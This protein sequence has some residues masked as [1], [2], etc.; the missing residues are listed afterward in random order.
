MR[1]EASVRRRPELAVAGSAFVLSLAVAALIVRPFHV[2]TAGYDAAASVLYFER[3]S[4]GRTLEAFVGATPKALLTGV[5]GV[6]FSIVP[7]W[8]VVSWLAILAYAAGIS[9]SAT[10]AYRLAGPVA[11]G[12]VAVGLVG[13]A[14]LLQDVDLAYAVSWALLACAVAGLLVSAPKPRYAW[15]GLTLAVGGLARAETLII[16]VLAG[17]LIVAGTLIARRRGLPTNAL[18]D[19]GPILLG[20]LAIP[21][22]AGH[23]WLLTGDPLYA[24]RVPVLGSVG[25]PLVGVPGAIRFVIGH[26]AGEPLLIVLAVVG[27]AALAIRRR[28]D[29]VTGLLAL[30]PGVAAFIVFLG[31][32]RIYV[33]N[34]Y[35]APADL[36]ITFA[37]GIGLANVSVPLLKRATR[38]ARRGTGRALAAALVG[39]LVAFVI[40][41]PFGPI[42]LPTRRAIVTNGLV[43]RDVALVIAPIDA[44]LATL[45]HARDWPADGSPTGPT[46]TRAV[47]LV[48]ILTVPQMA[49]DLRLPLSTLTGTVATSI[50]TDGSYPRI[51][52]LVFH[53]VDRDRPAAAFRIFEVDRSTSA[54]AILLNPILVDANHRFWLDRIDP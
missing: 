42:D 34:R 12:F 9:A 20:L 49:V 48:P 29:V 23:D 4:S 52:Q 43:H 39:G 15:A 11:A 50:A 38:V 31:L 3:I 25:L 21:I 2:G 18:R 8:R 54:G 5:Y 14:E 47:L 35:I 44:A 19:R 53:D 45:E 30:G 7:D 51:G 40:V 32:Q 28:M 46:G 13:S 10:L 24:Q 41:R 16:V 33:S 6:A 17:V 22:Q 26:Y 27:L 1:P 37:A 36:A